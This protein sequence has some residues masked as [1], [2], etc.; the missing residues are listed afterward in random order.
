MSVDCLD[1]LPWTDHEREHLC[2]PV[3]IV[4]LEV[5]PADLPCPEKLRGVI[6][7]GA[8]PVDR[9]LGQLFACGFPDL[10]ESGF[11]V[12]LRVV[13]GAQGDEFAVWLQDIV[14]SC[15]GAV[16]LVEPFVVEL[17]HHL[18]LV[19]MAVDDFKVVPDTPVPLR[20]ARVVLE[21]C[22]VAGQAVPEEP[23]LADRPYDIEVVIKIYEMFR[24]SGYLMDVAFYYHRVVGGKEL[25][26]D[27]VLVVYKVDLRVVR[28][29]PF[30]FLPAC[31]K[32]YLPYP[33]GEF[34]HSAEPVLQKSVV[35]ETGF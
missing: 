26:R 12:R 13:R 11:Q 14:P 20:P 5:S 25:L 17:G 9:C 1:G 30:R 16:A 21:G 6:V 29:E 22:D 2:I 28:I 7:Q 15:P 35:A 27:I 34:L 8:E 24:Q 33:R 32:M 10:F 4:G 3:G 31:N 19:E 23:L 18:F